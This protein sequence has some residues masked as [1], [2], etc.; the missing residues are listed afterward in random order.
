MSDAP[1][2]GPARRPAP[3]G[4]R[5][6]AVVDG[7]TWT[8]IPARWL[9][10]PLVGT[11][12]TASHVTWMR[13][14]TGV[15]ACAAL[16]LGTPA[17]AWWG[18]S[19]WLLSALLDRADGDLARLAGTASEAGRRLDFHA[20]AVVN[21]LFFLA[22]G[23][24]SRGSWLGSWAIPLGI[25]SCVSV[26]ACVWWSE[27]LERRQGGT[28]RAYSG[29]WGFDPDDALYLLGPLAWLG[30]LA[31]LLVGASV[32]ATAVMVLTGLRLYRAPR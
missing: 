23:F 32:G 5:L 17:G 21:P 16:A 24:A 26:F 31:P 29:R 6:A 12:V 28:A 27:L 3:R 14:A 25:L 13:I 20:D 10:R 18:G 8:H 1:L 15:A 9:V 4:R 7:T 30:W 2:G 19:L 22:A 11:G